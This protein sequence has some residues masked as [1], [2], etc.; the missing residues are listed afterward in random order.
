M[1]LH[2][3]PLQVLIE[4]TKPLNGHFNH[5]HFR[6]HS[7]QQF[8]FHIA[9]IH[10]RHLWRPHHNQR[11]ICRSHLIVPRTQALTGIFL[12]HR[13]IQRFS[14]FREHDLLRLLP[15]VLPL[16]SN[17]RPTLLKQLRHGGLRCA[18]ANVSNTAQAATTSPHVKSRGH[19][20]LSIIRSY[21]NT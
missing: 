14:A 15:H 6:V 10:L 17:I 21:M 2:T 12:L 4:A 11:N 1:N 3:V 18:C 9:Y 13:T 16:F 5:T 19:C 20:S 8:S 7:H